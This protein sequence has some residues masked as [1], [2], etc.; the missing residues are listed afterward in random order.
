LR[1]DGFSLIEVLV[2]AGILIVGVV[3]L[4]Q[5]SLV[6]AKANDDARATTMATILAQQKMEQ[7]RAASWGSGILAVSPPGVLTGDRAGF[8]DYL[9]ATG[10]STGDGFSGASA[11]TRFVRRWSIAALPSHPS[12]G[13]ILQVVVQRLSTGAGESGGPGH[14]HILS[15]RTRWD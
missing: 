2:A 4:A 1:A 10:A 13:V 6:G 9:D 15:V 8:V 5:L 12:D 11:D 3:G 14:A 7:L